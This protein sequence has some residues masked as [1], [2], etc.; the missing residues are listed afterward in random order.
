MLRK[1]LGR[2]VKRLRLGRQLNQ[3]TLAKRVGVSQPYIV[4]LE[5]GRENPTLNTLAKL[6][7][8][9]KVPVADLL[10]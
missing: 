9:F 8:A 7:K 6:A 2:N 4:A 3:V 10:K 5:K 1:T